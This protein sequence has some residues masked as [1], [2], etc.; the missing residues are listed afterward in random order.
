MK[1]QKSSPWQIVLTL[2]LFLMAQTTASFGA[3]IQLNMDNLQQGKAID[4]TLLQH[5]PHVFIHWSLAT[6]LLLVLLLFVLGLCRK[7]C[8]SRSDDTRLTSKQFAEALLTMCLWAIASSLLASALQLP[9]DG[10]TALFNR[11]KS[12]PI[13]GIYLCLIAPVVEELVF[14]EHTARILHHRSSTLLSAALSATLFSI[15]HG[16]PSQSLSAL[17]LG[18]LLG[19]F[20][21]RTGNLLLCLTAHVLNNLAALSLLFLPQWNPQDTN[22]AV[23]ILIAVLLFASGGW[24]LYRQRNA[25]FKPSNPSPCV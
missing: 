14:R 13:C 12:D 21:F 2:F 15:I 25:Y 1:V 20:Y 8:F 17:T 22:P 11:I 19:L 16:N 10:T 24:L 9:D 4:E 7:N 23:H 18:F 6:G 5:H 3:L